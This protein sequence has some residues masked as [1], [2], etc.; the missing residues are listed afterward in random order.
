MRRFTAISLILILALA[1]IIHSAPSFAQDT[2]KDQ[3]PTF[4]QL[5]PGTYVNGWPRFTIHYPKDWV[6]KATMA[7]EI[8]R[9]GGRDPSSPTF[10]Y[11]PFAPPTTP[12]LPQLDKLADVVSSLF[13]SVA[14][15]VTVVSDRPS[16]L[17]DGT[18][19]QEFELRFLSNGVTVYGMGLAA[20]KDDIYINMGL[21]SEGRKLDENLKAIPYSIEFEPDKDK[22]VKVPADVRD[23]LDQTGKAYVAHDSAQLMRGYSDNYLNSGRTKGERERFWRPI[24]NSITSFRII[25]TEFVPMADKAYITGFAETNFGKIP[26]QDTSIIKEGGSWKWYGN[27]RRIFPDTGP[28]H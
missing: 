6:E 5:V 14:T 20:M 26:V 10:I 27:Q 13:K 16:K 18:P 23:F 4:Y 7:Q 2:G 22:P 11:A 17:R 15:D 25:I 24:I 8:L 12:K 9:L 21:N 28:V 19:A 3:I 1:T